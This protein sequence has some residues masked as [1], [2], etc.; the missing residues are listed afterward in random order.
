MQSRWRGRKALIVGAAVAMIGGLTAM[1]AG[2]AL[3]DSPEDG[4]PPA[5][6]VAEMVAHS[7]AG[8]TVASVYIVTAES[9]RSDPCCRKLGQ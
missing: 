4:Q 6:T 9:S 8:G 1:V 7:P 5:I 2:P 3:G